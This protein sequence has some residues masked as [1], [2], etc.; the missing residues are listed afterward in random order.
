MPFKI[1]LSNYL[2]DKIDDVAVELK[3]VKNKQERQ[4]QMLTT[5]INAT[6]DADYI[7]QDKLLS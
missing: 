5:L 1:N 4:E 2:I 7:L 6:G 3:T